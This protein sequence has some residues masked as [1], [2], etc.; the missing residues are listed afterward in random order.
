VCGVGNPQIQERHMN[1]FEFSAP[2]VA[3][4][5]TA[6]AMAAV[7]LGV[8]VVLPAQLDSVSPAA[9]AM[10]SARAASVTSSPVRVG[11]ERGPVRDPADD[12]EATEAIRASQAELG[13]AVLAPQ[14]S[15]GRHHKASAAG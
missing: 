1:G 2:R 12:A 14:P 9:Y 13:C 8:L 6:V 10:S 11:T 4:G 15:S 7:T 5:L 3:L